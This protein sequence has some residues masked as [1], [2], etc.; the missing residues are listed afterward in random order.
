MRCMKC[1]SSNADWIS[2]IDKINRIKT[3]TF[4]CLDCGFT[5]S[6]KKDWHGTGEQTFANY[7]H[8]NG[9]VYLQSERTN[10]KHIEVEVRKSGKGIQVCPV[11]KQWEDINN[12]TLF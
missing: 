10:G 1:K 4:K 3:K 8:K 9:K 7:L 11:G 6:S 12:T 5:F 2:E